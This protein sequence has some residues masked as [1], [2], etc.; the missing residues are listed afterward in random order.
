MTTEFDRVFDQ[1]EAPE[2]PATCDQCGEVGTNATMEQHECSTE[3]VVTHENQITDY[4]KGARIEAIR[5][6]PLSSPAQ[7]YYADPLPRGTRGVVS[8]HTDDGRAYINFEGHGQEGFGHTFDEPEK[9]IR[10][11]CTHR[12]NNCPAN[13]EQPRPEQAGGEASEQSQLFPRYSFAVV[14]GRYKIL[15]NRSDSEPRV[16]QIA[17]ADGEDEARVIVQALNASEQHY[18]KAVDEAE[19]SRTTTGREG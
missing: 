1:M 2:Y 7:N 13:R 3:R 15:D 8:A 5:E 12:D 17:T 16:Q 4:P 11:V 18:R 6:I 19:R 14:T 9:Y 10:V